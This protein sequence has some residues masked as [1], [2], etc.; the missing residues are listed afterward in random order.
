MQNYMEQ[1]YFTDF[2][3]QVSLNLNT[4]VDRCLDENLRHIILKTYCKGSFPTTNAKI[5]PT[6]LTSGRHNSALITD[7]RKFTTK[8]TLYGILAFIFTVGIN[9]KSFLWSV[10]SVQEPPQIFCDVRR[11]LTT[12]HVTLTSFSRRQP[13]TIDY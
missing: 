5:S 10:H 6:F 4:K 11:G 7:R 13:I 1:H 2:T 12:R 9:S 3:G 8:I